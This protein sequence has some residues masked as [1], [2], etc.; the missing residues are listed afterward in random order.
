MFTKESVRINGFFENHISISFKSSLFRTRYYR[1]D[2]LNN[3][4]TKPTFKMVIK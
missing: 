4:L 1:L 2:C 3:S